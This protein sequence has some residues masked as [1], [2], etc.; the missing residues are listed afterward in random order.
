MLLFH[1]FT[2]TKQAGYYRLDIE[3]I[4]LI[5]IFLW[6]SYFFYMANKCETWTIKRLVLMSS[7]KPSSYLQANPIYSHRE[8]KDG[9]V[10]TILCSTAR[11]SLLSARTWH[12]GHVPQLI[13]WV[14]QVSFQIKDRSSY[15]QAN[16]IYNSKREKWLPYC[17]LPLGSC[18]CQLDPGTQG[19]CPR[20]S[21]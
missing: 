19:T 20:P 3:S 18:Y 1:K 9:Q 12:P 10:I 4:R 11:E 2:V 17:V 21:S 16:P 7:I 14:P 6:S 15:L 5:E 8:L 13:C